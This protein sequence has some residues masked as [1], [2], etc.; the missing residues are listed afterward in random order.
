MDKGLASVTDASNTIPG[1][2]QLGLFPG[3]AATGFVMATH[4]P[5]QALS[6]AGAA[7]VLTGFWLSSP[8]LP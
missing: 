3:S 5:L 6:L 8:S 4:T 2:S 1:V 7:G